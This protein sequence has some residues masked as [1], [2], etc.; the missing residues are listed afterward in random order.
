M[1]AL[2]GIVLTGAAIAAAPALPGAPVQ[3]LPGV[4]FER[5]VTLTAHGPVA[6]NVIVAPRPGGLLALEPALSNDL[7]P[8]TE[9]LTSIQR[10]LSPTATTVGVAGD[11]AVAD[12]RPVG[13]VLRAGS[14]LH[15]PLATRVSIGIDAAGDLRADQV[16]LLG[17]WQASGPRRALSLVNRAPTGNQL[18]VFTPA[19]GP[20]TPSASGTVEVVLQGVPRTPPGS[21]LTGTI[22]TV[23]NGGGSVI[24]PDGVV[25][26]ARGSS[27]ANLTAEAK[28]G[29]PVKLRLILK[30][31]WS[32]VVDGIGGG[33]LLVRGGV[34]DFRPQ[35][36]FPSA[37]LL[38]RGPRS[39]VGQRADGSLVLVAVDG[40]RLGTS[41]GMTSF[42]LAQAMVRQGCVLA[43]GLASGPQA[44]MAF[45]GTL[46]SQPA[47]G[48]LP[49]T[50]ALL[51]VYRGVYVAPLQPVLSPDGDRVADTIRLSYKTISTAQVTATLT[52]PDGVVRLTDQ[53]ARV[54]QR[55]SLIWNGLTQGAPDSEGTYRWTVTA[56][57]DQSR[58]SSMERTFTLN[59]T[60]ARLKAAGVL[61]TN[62]GTPQPLAAF[63]TTRAARIVTTILSPLGVPAATLPATSPAPGQQAITWDGKDVNGTAVPPG[64]YTVSVT[65]TNDVG[66]VTRTATLVVRRA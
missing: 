57:D 46:L 19:W 1:L 61:R 16:Q 6:L 64:R 7:I 28:P 24:P 54:A 53:G 21:E 10:R 25:L 56:T 37:D 30:P 29:Q 32:Q 60:L 58:P 12:G 14:L 59:R 31:D 49:I 5:Q 51:L 39:A 8:G 26:V 43:A 62:P 35:D 33:P 11:F 50:D 40:G 23:T 48:E 2:G 17:T 63:D 36:I 65:A 55:Y 34:A 52:G 18:S 9:T 4:T 22:A 44:G 66:T 45:D 38:A 3:L 42:E 47:R 15:T 13:I 41:V 20:T 27:A